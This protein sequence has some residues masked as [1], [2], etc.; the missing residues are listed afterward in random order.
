MSACKEAMGDIK[1]VSPF[2]ISIGGKTKLRVIGSG[3]VRLQV[4]VDGEAKKFTLKH[5][6][7]VPKV[8]YH[9]VSVSAMDR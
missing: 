8:G 4:D 2:E 5:V 6:L 9:L 3:H 7:H 1:V